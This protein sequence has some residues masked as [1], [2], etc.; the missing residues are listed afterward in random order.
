L[1]ESKALRHIGIVGTIG[2]GRTTTANYIQ[3]RF[4]LV[5]IDM[6]AI[7]EE[8]LRNKGIRPTPKTLH[9]ASVELRRTDP[10]VVAKK[11]VNEWIPWI[12]DPRAIEDPSQIAF[13]FNGIRNKEEVE[14][15]RETYKKDIT[16]IGLW[17][18]IM[19]R[20]ERLRHGKRPGFSGM[21]FDNFKRVD[22][23]ELRIFDVGNT[24]TYA[25]Y[26]LVND[27]TV[28]RLYDSINLVLA[29]IGMKQLT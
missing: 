24:T 3:K 8:E 7:V 27:K 12:E 19:I 15:L 4:G 29:Q 20:F 14:F 21:K 16:I 9:E 13:I 11:A 18:P 22:E 6:S 28:E 1:P 26:L 17:A 2:S 5:E 10:A 25:D 23:D